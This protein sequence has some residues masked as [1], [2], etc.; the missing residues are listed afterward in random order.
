MNIKPLA[1]LSLFLPCLCLADVHMVMTERGDQEISMSYYVSDG[2]VRMEDSS[3]GM[4]AL[5][6]SADD[7]LTTIDSRTKTYYV[8]DRETVDRAADQMEQMM[9]QAQEMMKDMPEEQRR[10]MEQRLPGFGATK[11][12]QF[13]VERNGKKDRVGGIACEMVTVYRDDEATQTACVASA[14]A[15][16]IDSTDVAAVDALFARMRSMASRFGEVQW[17]DLDDLGGMPIM[18]R[19]AATGAVTELEELSTDE[20]PAEL[21]AVPADYRQSAPMR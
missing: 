14:K 12:P 2:K 18:G 8:L 17:P 9:Q 19:D 15:L 5:F 10:M 11:T 7:T 6:D 4:V 16:G 21:F 3:T 1:T 20:Q 13:R